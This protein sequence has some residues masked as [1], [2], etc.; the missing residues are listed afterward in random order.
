MWGGAKYIS[1]FQMKNK[2]Q[3]NI[4][5]AQKIAYKVSPRDQAMHFAGRGVEIEMF[6]NA[7]SASLD[8]EQSIFCI[9]QGAPGCGKTSLAHHLAKTMRDD[10]VSVKI[11][12]HNL[13]SRAS[14]IMRIRDAAM[15]QGGQWASLA[16]LWAGMSLDRLS[17]AISSEVQKG[18]ANRSV[19]GLRFAL[20]VDEAHSLDESELKVLKGLHV[21]GLGEA[22]SI[23]SV[24]V[25]TGL[26]QTKEHISNYPGL[27]RAA[28]GFTIE[29]GALSASECEESTSQMLNDL[30][31]GS[32]GALAKLSASES[33]GWPR[34][35]FSVQ[36]VICEELIE[37]NGDVN[38]DPNRISDRSER[39]R[40]SYYQRRLEE[41]ENYKYH[42]KSVRRVLATLGVKEVNESLST[43][44]QLLSECGM[45]TTRD[46]ESMAKNMVNRGLLKQENDCWALSI[47]SMGSWARKQINVQTSKGHSGIGSR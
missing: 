43:L 31:I 25:L 8:R 2:P 41:V 4:D 3:F 40:F 39:K 44:T 14:L 16:I 6:R 29:M 28:D 22:R 34:H 46:A 9:Y 42:K 1:P 32:S 30:G 18:A 35:L 20:H 19:E 21:G 26:Q 47:P 45:P 17:G 36:K 13:E 15:A 27:T 37:R 24:V 38:I 5:L 33:F 10:V 23:P 7:L 11:S 12:P